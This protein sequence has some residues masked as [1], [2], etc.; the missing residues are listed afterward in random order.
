MSRRGDNI[1]HRKDGRWEARYVKGRQNGRAVY[2]YVYAKS[3]KEA[4]E[5][6][7]KKIKESSVDLPSHCNLTMGDLFGMYMQNKTYTVK[8]STYA[9]YK[10]DICNHLIPFWENIQVKNINSLLFERFT[11]LR[12]FKKAICKR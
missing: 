7:A 8:Q 10:R 11:L 6:Q 1:W 4:K 3:Y 5:K 2:G 12:K 9:K